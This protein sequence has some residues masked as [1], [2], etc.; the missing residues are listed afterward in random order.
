M[1]HD[2]V[3]TK[4]RILDATVELLRVAKDANTITIRQIAKKADI[5]V[6]LVNYYFRSKENLLSEAIAVSMSDIAHNIFDNTPTEEEPI[7]K[8]RS[9]LKTNSTLA[10]NNYNLSKLAVAIDLKQGNVGTSQMILPILKQIYGDK[11]S[12]TEL[13]LLSFQLIIPLQAMFLN[14]KKYNDY[15]LIDIYDEEQRN[16]A[17]DRMID[18]ILKG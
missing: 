11:R 4:K 18:N 5:N 3:N 2:G 12:E 7:V 1:E 16:Q 8:L 13:K 9:M 15:L 17:I 14:P 6:A 10:F